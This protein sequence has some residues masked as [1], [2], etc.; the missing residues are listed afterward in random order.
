MTET[1]ETTVPDYMSVRGLFDTCLVLGA[2]NGIGRQCAH[3]F[4]QAGFHVICVDVVAERAER[5]AEEVRGTAVTADLTDPAEFVRLVESLEPN[6]SDIGPVVDVVG[7]AYFARLADSTDDLWR[8]Q[9]GVVIDHARYVLRDLAPRLSVGATVTFV[10]SAVGLGG[11]QEFGLYAAAKAAVISLVKTA[12][13]ELGPTGIRINSVAPGVVGTPRM[14][15]LLGPER[16]T[17]FE[18]N[19][20]LGRLASP[21]DIARS[22]LFLGTQASDHVNGHVLVVDGGIDGRFPYPP[23][24]EPLA[25]S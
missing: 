5:V 18:Q 9:T 16:T 22:A 3:A 25:K 12:A 10:S 19:S 7:I 8:Q 1:D 24:T 23:F 6:L 21:S 20:P 15:D 11:G 4:A 13:V 2:G 17:R 14:L